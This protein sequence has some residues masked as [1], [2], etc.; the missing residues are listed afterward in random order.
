MRLIC[1]Q[2]YLPEV[3]EPRGLGPFRKDQVVRPRLD[4]PL[5]VGKEYEVSFYIR[6]ISEY[7]HLYVLCVFTDNL[8]YEEFYSEPS[9]SKTFRENF[10]KDLSVLFENPIPR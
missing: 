8:E 2:N 4:F 9:G 5:T 3:I 7:T 10:F 6:P 1:K